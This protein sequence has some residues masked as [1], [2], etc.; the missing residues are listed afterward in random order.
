MIL[1]NPMKNTRK[2]ALDE[3]RW[4]INYIFADYLRKFI[5]IKGGNARLS[6]MSEGC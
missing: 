3:V 2:P 1:I 6:R 4:H 5:E